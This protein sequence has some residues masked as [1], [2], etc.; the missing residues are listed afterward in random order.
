MR[1]VVTQSTTDNEERKHTFEVMGLHPNACL[2]I[3]KIHMCI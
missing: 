2:K 1:L 3:L